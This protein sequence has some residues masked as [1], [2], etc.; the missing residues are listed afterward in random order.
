[1][2]FTL[3]IAYFRHKLGKAANNMAIALKVGNLKQQLQDDLMNLFEL[4]SFAQPELPNI[5]KKLT[6]LLKLWEYR[7]D[8]FNNLRYYWPHHQESLMKPIQDKRDDDDILVA[9]QSMRN[10]EPCAE[11]YIKQN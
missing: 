7:I 6:E 1:M 4:H 5:A 9:M 10:V 3:V 8:E 2:L 11:I